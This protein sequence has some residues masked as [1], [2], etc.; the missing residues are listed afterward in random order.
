MSEQDSPSGR[1]ERAVPTVSMAAP[2]YIP[3]P[4][5]DLEEI[6]SD[7]GDAEEAPEIQA[8]AKG[9]F[10][11]WKKPAKK[12]PSKRVDTQ[13]SIDR[14]HDMVAAGEMKTR[15][16]NITVFLLVA[17]LGLGLIAKLMSPAALEGG[18]D[19][20]RQVMQDVMK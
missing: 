14:I 3:P 15:M 19:Q 5:P 20:S 9:F 10:G 12:A 1:V 4:V 8:P 11:R 7:A 13:S 16:V 17:A 18:M 2:D 6:P